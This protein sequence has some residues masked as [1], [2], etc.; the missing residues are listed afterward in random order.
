MVIQRNVSEWTFFDVIKAQ[1]H[2]SIYHEWSIK[3]EY[4]IFFVPFI[5]Y[6]HAETSHTR[7]ESWVHAS[8]QKQRIYNKKFVDV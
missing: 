7:E 1:F 6:E 2:I 8:V 4:I 3:N 5:A